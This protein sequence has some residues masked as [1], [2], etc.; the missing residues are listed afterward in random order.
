MI[1]YISMTKTL[2]IAVLTNVA[3]VTSPQKGGK[4]SPLPSSYV[5]NVNSK[6]RFASAV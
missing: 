1:L 5:D 3:K 2:V 6:D 4:R